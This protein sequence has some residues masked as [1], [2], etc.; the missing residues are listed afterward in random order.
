MDDFGDEGMGIVHGLGRTQP[1]FWRAP[2]S[3][4]SALVLPWPPI[5]R[6]RRLAAATR[7]HQLWVQQPSGRVDECDDLHELLGDGEVGL[8][9]ALKPVDVFISQAQ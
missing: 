3:V 8:G 1:S 9:G 5:W 6:R 4:S 2:A 7:N